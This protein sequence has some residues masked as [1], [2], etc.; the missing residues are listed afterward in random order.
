MLSKNALL[1]ST[2]LAKN[3]RAASSSAAKPSD[4]TKKRDE[5]DSPKIGA[6]SR[7]IFAREAKYGAHNYHPLPVAISRAKGIHVWDV[8]GHRYFDFLSAYSAVNQ[9]HCHPR[10]ME[11]LHDQASRLT[12]TSRA[13]Y[14]DVLGEFEEYTAKLFGYDK[15]LAMNTGVEAGETSIKLAR[16]WGY[17]VKGIPEN[18][19]ICLFAADNFW[20]RTLSACSSSTDPSCYNGFGPFMP[21]FIS[22]PYN[23]LDELEEECRSNNVCSFMVEPIQG[24]AGVVVPNEGYLRGVREICDRYNVLW[25]AD[26]V[27]TGL[28]R[29][30][31]RL[32]V[33]YEN[34]KPDILVLGK[35][36]SGGV[37]PVSAAL[38][39]DEIMLSIKPGEHGS[40]YGGN[41]LGARLAITALRVI[42][43]EKLA[44][45][46][47]E[48]GELFRS[49]LGKRLPKEIVTEI[50]GKGLLNAI[51][52]NKEHDAWEFCLRLKENGLL[53]KPT[54]GDKIR[55][56][57]P[58]IINKEQM[59][60]AI[61][62][63]HKTA[64]TFA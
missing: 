55:F 3:V 2:H 41:P 15:V 53:A 64:M 50:R 35:A 20:G 56:A 61:D 60:E 40:T 13:F 37:M 8:E 29:T 32:C 5:L 54:H 21:N 58:L 44:E 14:N 45:N 47:F 34:V 48:M 12:L 23:N 30:G 36:L 39:R 24:E 11:T 63:I 52:I 6:K 27:Q 9:G 19:A 51:V 22:V 62:I 57:P 59:Q 33:D 4:K 17:T 42:E 1:R 31:K 16:K 49:E 18:E 26:E 7:E 28:G 25:I 38:A 46:S 10:I 43:E